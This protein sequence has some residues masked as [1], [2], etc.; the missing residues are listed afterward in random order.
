MQGVAQGHEKATPQN[1]WCRPMHAYFSSRDGQIRET[2][3]C[4]RVQHMQVTA[5]LRKMLNFRALHGNRSCSMRPRLSE[6]F[7]PGDPLK[8]RLKRLPT[9]SYERTCCLSSRALV[10]M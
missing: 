10:I 7:A 5:P 9:P 6:G 8:L 4:T 3:R 2:L 1:P